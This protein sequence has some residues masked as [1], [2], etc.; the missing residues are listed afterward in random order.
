MKT[1]ELGKITEVSFGHGGYQDVCFGLN[2]SFL[3]G[4]SVTSKFISGGWDPARMEWDSLASWTEK[5][6]DK[7]LAKMC[8]EVSKILHVAKVDDVSKLKGIPVEVEIEDNKLKS[9][10]ILSEVL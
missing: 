8:R 3:F 9:W 10:R 2:L 6:R 5:D 1:K 7:S 4:D